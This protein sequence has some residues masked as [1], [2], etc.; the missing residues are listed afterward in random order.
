MYLQPTISI[1]GI[2]GVIIV[3]PIFPATANGKSLLVRSTD[4]ETAI[5]LLH[6][7]SGVGAIGPPGQQ[8][9]YPNPIPRKSKQQPSIVIGIE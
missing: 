2:A 5:L 9:Q 3:T 7:I 4:T 6:T 8:W 1:S